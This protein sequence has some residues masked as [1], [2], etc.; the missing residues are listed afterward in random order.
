MRNFSLFIFSFTKIYCASFL[1]RYFI[2]QSLTP[3][4]SGFAILKDTTLIIQNWLVSRIFAN[5]SQDLNYAEEHIWQ[6]SY[7]FVKI[8]YYDLREKSYFNYKPNIY[9]KSQIKT[10]NALD[11]FRIPRSWEMNVRKFSRYFLR[12]RNV[13]SK[14]AQAKWK[15]CISCDSLGITVCLCMFI[16][17]ILSFKN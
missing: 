8:R 17:Q 5:I 6:F 11:Q 14:I 1:G 16:L 13:V 2:L 7:F 3:R 12:L 10:I 9:L 15:F 4:L